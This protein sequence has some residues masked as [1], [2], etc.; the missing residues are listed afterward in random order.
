VSGGKHV[1]IVTG[2]RQSGHWHERTVMACGCST[3]SLNSGATRWRLSTNRLKRASRP[4]TW[5]DSLHCI[6]PATLAETGFVR[7]TTVSY[8]GTKRL[9]L[10]T[11]SPLLLF[12]PRRSEPIRSD[13]NSSGP[14]DLAR[15]TVHPVLP[16]PHGS[17]PLHTCG[18][19]P[20]PCGSTIRSAIHNR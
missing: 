5:T 4:S 14:P 6:V 15:Y 20:S 12:P 8:V 11:E 16:N 3:S 9:T 13:L 1:S 19:A 7:I 2:I 17:G 10:L 18:L